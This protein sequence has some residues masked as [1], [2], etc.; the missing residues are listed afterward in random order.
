MIVKSW[1]INFVCSSQRISA[2]FRHVDVL[3]LRDGMFGG[4]KPEI[5][6]AVQEKLGRAGRLYRK[7]MFCW[8]IGFILLVVDS[9]ILRR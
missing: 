2:R 1:T 5:E 7:V 8:F 9:M 3:A 4:K 6:P